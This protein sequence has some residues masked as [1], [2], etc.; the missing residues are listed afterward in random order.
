MRI[1]LIFLHN[2]SASGNKSV[3]L[4][5]TS[6]AGMLTDTLLIQH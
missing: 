5:I 1:K 4:G 3:G 2:P 6:E